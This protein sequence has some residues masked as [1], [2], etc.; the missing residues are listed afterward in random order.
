MKIQVVSSVNAR[1]VNANVKICLPDLGESRHF[2][3]AILEAV[4]LGN[5]L[6]TVIPSGFDVFRSVIP[7][8]KFK[9]AQLPGG[10]GEI[11]VLVFLVGEKFTYIV[12]ESG[13]SEFPLLKAMT[14][15][16]ETIAKLEISK[17]TKGTLM[18]AMLELFGFA[19]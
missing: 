15:M 9:L 1:L 10:T 2:A 18:I 3:E 7:E 6:S 14:S 8:L 11:Y 17:E 16:A 12:P 19:K 13:G 5:D 4:A